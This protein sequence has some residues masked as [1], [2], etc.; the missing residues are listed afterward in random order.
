LK[1]I[2]LLFLFI[3]L[4]AQ[5]KYSIK[6]AYGEASQSNLGEIIFGD[7]SSHPINLSVI[8]IDGGYLLAKDIYD[9]PIDIYVKAGLSYFNEGSYKDPIY[10]GVIYIKA[11]YNL[12]AWDNRVRFGIAEGFSYTTNIL[13]CEHLEAME[14]FDN[15]SKFLNYLDISIDFDVGKLV[16]YKPLEDTY[17][18]WAIKHRS[19]IAGLIND[20]SHGGSNYNTLYIESNF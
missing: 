9:M 1:I 10:E 14:K 8:A 15:T 5:D 7:F 16:G 20:V 11:Y 18:G 13:L 17:F 3:N 2:I 19:G 4:I 12:D 6:V